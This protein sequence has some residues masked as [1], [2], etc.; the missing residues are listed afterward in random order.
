MPKL[1]S[2]AAKYI[3]N[4]KRERHEL[5]CSQQHYLQ[6]PWLW[7]PPKCPP[8]DEWIKMW[9]YVW[10]N[11]LPLTHHK[12]WNNAISSNMGGPRDYHTK[13]NK[14]KREGQM[15]YDI[16]YKWKL[17]YDTNQVLYETE[18][19]SQAQRSDLWF[20][21]VVVHRLSCPVACGVLPG[22]GLNPCR[23]HWQAGFLISGS[24]GS[25]VKD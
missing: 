4:K 23:L 10:Y 11:G 19:E 22:Q 9:Y 20:S 1:R 6:Q 24:Q 25:P 7:K 12:E 15:P 16:T 14:S 3:N 8:T 13:W 18:T 5:L 21:I 2:S 17:N